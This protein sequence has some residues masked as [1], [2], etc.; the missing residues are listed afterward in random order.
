MSRSPAN[1]FVAARAGLHRR[2]NPVPTVHRQRLLHRAINLADKRTIT[3]PSGTH[4]TGANATDTWSGGFDATWEAD[5][6]GGLRRGVESAYAN[7]LEATVED[8][9]DVLVTLLAE[10]AT[11]YI[12]LRGF[13]QQVK[14]GQDN[15]A[16]QSHT[17]EVTREKKGFGVVSGLDVANSEAE[18]ASTSAQIALF[19]NLVQQ[20][21]YAISVLLGD[22]PTALI[23]EL[24]PEAE[25]PIAPPLVPV[26]LPAELLRRRP[27]IRRSERLLA[28]ATADIGVATADLFPHFGLNG[29]L[30]VGGAR[31]E[32]LGNL[33][34]SALS[35]GPSFNWAIFDGGRIW[36]NIE[37]KNAVQAQAL[38]QYH[39]TVLTALQDVESALTAYAQEQQRRAQLVESVAANQ[40]AVAFAQELYGEG[41]KDFL[42]VLVSQES[43]L[44]AQ[45]A[46]VQ[47]NQAVAAN[48]VA[49]YKAL[50]GGWEVG[51][52]AP[53]TRPV[54]E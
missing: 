1:V 43:L 22:E 12:Q 42:N 52:R 27:D 11:D 14:I 47:S 19:Q 16:A 2:I 40:R 37:V 3:T 30:T 50:G 4:T 39:Q 9:R 48:L 6:F 23:Q 53:T 17:L 36:S 38:L 46:L 49:I 8:R 41:V 45:N 33:G 32:N 5:I 24:S 20:Q 31:V 18:V 51:E 54:H 29:S 35:F 34:K 13:Q 10:V 28:A 26:G 25:I 15:L 44:S 21:I 7:L